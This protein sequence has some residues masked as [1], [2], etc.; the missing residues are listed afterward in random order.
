MDISITDWC[1]RECNICYRNSSMSGKHMSIADYERILI[2]GEKIHVL[3]IALG[4]GNPNQHPAFVEILR[5]TREEYGVIPSYTTNGRG[6]NSRILA[7]SRDY[8]GAVAVS[9]YEPYSEMLEAL[10][11]LEKHNIRANVHFVLTSQS[12]DAAIQWLEQPPG[13]LKSVNAL[14]FLNYKPVGNH[15]NHHLL[16]RHSGRIRE[17]YRLAVESGREFKVGFD[18]CLV[19]GLAKFTQTDPAMYDSCDSARFSMYIS[20]DLRMYP[21]SF[22][23][24]KCEGIQVNAHNIQDTWQNSKLFKSIR[25]RSYARACLRCG[26]FEVCRGGCVAFPEVNACGAC[27]LLGGYGGE[28]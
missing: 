22:M 28:G 20:T 6:L 24:D 14:V 11:L 27:D 23:V 1:D 5:L 18:S 16:I 26:K 7:A 13:F 4:G 8:C 9:A 25:N 2:Q 3:Q 15:K 21:C 17:F 12:V 19:S 10:R